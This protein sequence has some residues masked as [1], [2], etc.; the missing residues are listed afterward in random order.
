MPECL[1][2]AVHQVTYVS[3][4]ALAASMVSKVPGQSGRYFIVRNSDSENGLSLDT[5]GRLWVL[6]TP[7]SPSRSGAGE[8]VRFG[9]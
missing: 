8:G 6:A 3:L 7:R 4:W 9:V 1:W 2:L 5:R